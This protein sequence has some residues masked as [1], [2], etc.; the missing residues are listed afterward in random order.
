MPVSV[1]MLVMI[2]LISPPR[3]RKSHDASMPG[4]RG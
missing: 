1:L 3:V 4:S 2:G